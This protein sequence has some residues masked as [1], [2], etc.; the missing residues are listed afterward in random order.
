MECTPELR[1][2]AAGQS[3]R[4]R[5]RVGGLAGRLSRLLRLGHGTAGQAR[6]PVGRV[7]CTPD[8]RQ[9]RLGQPRPP[10]GDWSACGACANSDP[11]S[12]G[13]RSPPPAASA[14]ARHSRLPGAAA[15]GPRRSGQNRCCTACKAENAAGAWRD[16]GRRKACRAAFARRSRSDRLGR[17]P[18]SH[19][20]PG[21]GH[22][23]ATAFFRRW[24]WS[25]SW[26]RAETGAPAR[27]S[28]VD[29]AGGWPPSPAPDAADRRHSAA[30]WPPASARG[31]PHSARGWLRA[32][33]PGKP[34]PRHSAGASCRCSQPWSSPVWSRALKSFRPAS[35]EP[36][37][38]LACEAARRARKRDA[39]ADKA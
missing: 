22:R 25:S 4:P 21:S 10:S 35:A 39:R 9:G 36:R 31:R 12:A 20:R 38:D 13:L 17:L 37:H 14:R 8:L 32:C 33:L 19:S 1:Q 5:S 29:C 2:E 16:N 11:G 27:P 28:F 26:A 7:E 15:E 30:A 34:D 23:H 18:G 6:W 24:T 3:L